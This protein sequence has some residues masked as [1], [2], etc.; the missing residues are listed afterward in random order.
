MNKKLV[1]TTE[2]FFLTTTSAMAEV[3]WPVYCEEPGFILRGEPERHSDP[4][5]EDVL[6]AEERGNLRL[7]RRL[8]AS[9]G[10]YGHS[11]LGYRYIARLFGY[12]GRFG[13]PRLV[14]DWI[15]NQEAD[16]F[17][18]RKGMWKVWEHWVMH[19]PKLVEI[20]LSGF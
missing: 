14:E 5:D 17:G 2:L 8:A 16:R 7:A 20:R 6:N 1:F 10:P 19:P 13:S 4:D 11:A 3:E 12:R 18:R 15:L 9:P